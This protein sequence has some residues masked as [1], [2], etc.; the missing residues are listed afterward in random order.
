MERNY[1]TGRRKT[2]TARVFLAKGTGA[3]VVNGKP[4]DE[5][6]SRE[7]SRMVVRQ[8]LEL[9]DSANE[10]D[11][12]VTVAGGGIS[13]Q[14]GAIRHGITRAL[15]EYDETYRQPLRQAGFV[16]RD[17]REVDISDFRLMHKNKPFTYNGYPAYV[18][19]EIAKWYKKSWDKGNISVCETDQY[20][21]ER[22]ENLRYHDEHILQFLINQNHKRYTD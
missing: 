13:G 21:N 10:Y 16:T 5:Y 14:A 12:Y 7:T 15:M 19:A 2:S 1:G 3:I 8:P 9:L 11:L 17:A 4:L 22:R 20:G 6:F 18:L